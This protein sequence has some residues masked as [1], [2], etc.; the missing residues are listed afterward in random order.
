MSRYSEFAINRSQMIAEETGVQ[1]KPER[2]PDT[3][4]EDIEM[5]SGSS[6]NDFSGN[7]MNENYSSGH[8]SHGNESD[9]NGKDT[10]MLVESL[11]CHKSSNAF[12]LMI[13][14]SEHNP[15]TSGCSSE[16]STKAKTQQELRKTLQELKARLPPEK[17]IKGKSSVLATLKYA[18]KSIK[19]VKANEEY[20]QLMINESHPSGLDVSSYTVEEVENIT[21]E[22][23]MKNADMFA[24]AV[25]L[26]TGKVLYISDQAASIL[27]CKR[28][29][30]KNAKF[31]EFLAPQD[32][33][34]FYSST[35]SYRLPSWSICN[36]VEYSTQ[37]CMEEKSFF[38]RISAGKEHE[39]ICYHP[40]RITPYLIKIQDTE[41]AEDQL[42]CV[43]LAEKVHSGYEAPRI[44]PDKRIF[45]T[46][47]TPSCLFQDIDERAVPLLGYLPQDLIGTPVLL[48]L[49]PSDR[50]LMLAIHKKILQ[51]GGQPFDYSPIRFC[52]RNG[53][54]ITMDTSWSSFINPWSR[55]VSFIIGRHKVRTGP[56]NEDVFAAPTYTEDKILHP[57]I[58]EITEQIYRLLLQ[59]VHNSGS[60]GYGSL[61]SNGSHE[62]LM[63]IASSSDSNGNNNEETLKDKHVTCQDAHMARNE[64]QHV[65]TGRRVKLERKKKSFGEETNCSGVRM[66]DATE[67]DI[68]AIAAHK[69]VITEELAWKEQ[70]VYSYQQISCLD[71]VIRYLESCGIPGT[72]KRKCEP[73]SNA[74]SLSSD[75][76]KQK[77]A[78]NARKPSGEMIEDGPSGTE[79]LDSQLLVPPSSIIHVNQEKEPFKK[80]GL[81]KEIL[82]VHTQKEEQS[83][84][85]KF[86]EIKRFKI[87]Q[88]CCNYY[89]QDRPKGHPGER[90]ARGQRNG[91]SGGVQSWRKSGKNRKSKP[92]RIK[93]Q[94]SSDSTTSGPN[95]PHQFPLQGLNSTAWSPS[96]TS[97]A[98]HSAMSFPAIMPAY[99]LPVFS[100]AGTVPPGPEACLSGFSDL[101]DSGNNCPKQ[102]SQFSAP[103]VTPV[104]ALV[105][106]NYMYPQMNNNLPQTLYNGQPN[107]SADPAFSSQS[108]FSA[109][110]PLA[111]PNP[112]SRQTFFP[113]QRFHY[114]TLVESEKAPAM[115]SQNDPSRSSTP[116]SLGPQDHTSPPLFQSR[117]SSPLQLNLLQ[118]EETLKSAESG[119]AASLHGA[120][121]ER[122]ATD[123][124][125]TDDD[126]SRKG[127]SPIDSPMGAQNSDALSMSS[128]LLHIL[129]QEDTCSGTGSASSGSGVS[130]AAESLGSGSNGCGMTE[131]RTGSSE[132]SHTSKYFGSIDSS[133]N[134]HNTKKNSEMENSEHFIKYV[135]QDPIWLLMANT[136]DAVMMTYQIPSRNLE[137]VL[138]EDKQKLKQ[139]QKFQ[140][141]FTEEQKRELIEI[142][143]WIQKGGL[144]KAVAN[145]ECIYCEDNTR[146]CFYT[147]YDEEIHEMELNEMIEASEENNLATLNQIG[148]EQT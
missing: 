147:P 109:Q 126:S 18:L 110:P 85:N 54:Y 40:F 15:S 106:P 32:V 145:S 2:H 58:Q 120:L 11:D 116:Q 72:V 52:T 48:H 3:L 131:S 59:P 76:Q 135:L 139:M 35:T 4:Q 121:I 22:Y 14:D 39:Y 6:G 143:P 118:L 83:F 37:D 92:K 87:F 123:K 34:V 38:C 62:H 127:S 67:K 80:L 117:C 136:D 84:L 124:P 138:K 89:L 1:T 55:K 79:L 33:S 63:S 20:Y 134:N 19:Q 113:T 90:G 45:T 25:S 27:R 115:E 96:D 5:S 56:L 29:F 98:S 130:A 114:N 125:I 133:E 28:D 142:H 99:P 57:S 137:M 93:P 30:F 26:I 47:H 49:H 43:L 66:E 42:C 122:G 73:S 61:G 21:S 148:E 23:I 64:G 111:A 44:P 51:Y 10:A 82:A 74:A 128:D 16:Q 141:K 91:T 140:P 105:L 78:D 12:S 7:Y 71:S 95:P 75:D 101:P 129:L 24:V 13:A 69:N 94:E 53:E 8:D 100:A 46:M 31:V 17:R 146:S 41:T 108:V 81:T 36:G 77:T 88:S 65:F 68:V 9:E 104:V 103:L 132:T 86:K 97:Q 60:S 107:F 144:P 50:P 70:P 119:A 102:P 112:F